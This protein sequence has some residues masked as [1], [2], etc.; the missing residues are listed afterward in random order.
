MAVAQHGEPVAEPEHFLQ[1]VGDEDDRQALGLERSDDAGEIGDFRFAERRGR[2]V[3]DDE[4]RAHGKRARDLDELL[5]GDRK[6]ANQRHRVALEADLVGDRARVLGEAPPADEEL[7][8]RF[9]ADEHVLGDCHVG[10]EGEF[11]IDRDNAGALGVVGRREG[12]RLAIELDFA[13]VRAVRAG[14]NLEQRRLAGAVLAKQGVDL[15]VADFEM[16]VLERK[17]AGEALAD[18]GHLED[19]AV[20]RAAS[21]GRRRRRA[22]HSGATRWRGRR[23]GEGR[24]ADR[25]ALSTARVI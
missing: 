14:Q 3:H 8:T 23:F 9:A 1:P 11:L 24:A 12:D 17:H 5:L 10:G 4:P 19:R 16:D 13:R 2:L 18:P 7:R 25:R 6:I 20:R 15:G 22:G 21:G